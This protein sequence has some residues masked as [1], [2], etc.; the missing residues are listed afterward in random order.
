[1][2]PT[3]D[4]NAL[5]TVSA[6]LTLLVGAS[7]VAASLLR[8]GF[9]AN[10]ISEPVLVGYKA[11]IGF[12]IFLDQLS[13]I[14]GICFVRG[15]FIHNLRWTARELPNA[16]LPTLIVGL[17]TVFLLI[18]MERYLPRIPA[19][20]IAIGGGIYAVWLMNLHA[21]GVDLVGWVP[22]GLPPTTVPRL[23]M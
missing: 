10:F 4:L 15:S 6:T 12:V 8:L 14:F 9:V 20:L 16:S 23:T 3:G 1:I 13:K 7:L 17:L 19:P 11:G 22:Q 21:H 2:A 5:I 18:V